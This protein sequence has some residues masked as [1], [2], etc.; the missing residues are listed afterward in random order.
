MFG[1]PDDHIPDLPGLHRGGDPRPLRDKPGTAATRASTSSFTL[2]ENS[3]SHAASRGSL[4]DS[5]ERTIP[6]SFKR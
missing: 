4:P 6:S 1:Q 5:S 2:F 3:G